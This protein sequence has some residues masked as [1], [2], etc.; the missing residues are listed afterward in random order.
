M[1]RAGEAAVRERIRGRAPR[2]YGW[3]FHVSA[4]FGSWAA[5]VVG[6]LW[7]AEDVQPLQGLWVLAGM[8]L[9]YTAEYGLHRWPFHLRWGGALYRR[10]TVEHHNFFSYERPAI[11]SAEDLWLVLLPPFA[12]AVFWVAQVPLLLALHYGVGPNAPWLFVLGSL[13]VYYPI[14]EVPHFI[15]HVAVEGGRLDHPVW[16]AISRHHRL[17]HKLNLM[18]YNFSFGISVLDRLLGTFTR[19]LD[20]RPRFDRPSDRDVLSE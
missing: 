13:G 11:D 7:M 2:S 10:H 18:Q 8:G 14:Y 5:T 12:L 20:A 16:H 3:R 19:D 9:S 1:A 15:S 4:M 17:H 6:C